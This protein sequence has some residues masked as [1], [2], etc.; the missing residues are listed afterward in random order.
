[1]PRV[2]ATLLLGLAPVVALGV[3]AWTHRW[4]ADDAFINLRVVD[5]LLHGFGPVFNHG[6]RVEAYTSPAWVAILAVADLVTPFR[7]EWLAVVLGGLLT[8]AGLAA[9]C[10][11]AVVLARAAG[12][13]GTALPAGA[14]VVVALAPFWDFATS[15]LETGLSF[16]WLGTVFWLLAELAARPDSRFARPRL[17][18]V[19]IG[20]GPLIR[21]DLAVFSAGFLGVLLVLHRLDGR[22]GRLRLLVWAAALPVAYQIFRMGY[23]AAVVPNTA[24]AKEAGEAYWARGWFYLRDFALTYALW[25]PALV[26]LGLVALELW[27][28][29]R[30]PPGRR[31][32]LVIAVPLACGFLHALYVVRVG[33]DFMHAR[34]LLPSTFALTLPVAMVVP[35]AWRSLRLVGVVALACWALVCGLTARPEDRGRPP[36]GDYLGTTDERVLYSAFAGHAHPVALGDFRSTSWVR[37]ATRMRTLAGRGRLLTA[38][39]QS[40]VPFQEPRWPPLLPRRSVPAPVVASFYSVGVAGYAA[41]RDV[42][43]VD[44]LGLGDPVASRIRFRNDVRFP[45]GTLR[46]PRFYPG[47]EKVLPAEWVIARFADP[48]S[49]RSLGPR[50]SDPELVAARAA[51]GCGSLKRIL[52]AVT[53]SMSP[54]RFFS[55]LGVAWKLRNFRLPADPQRAKNELCG[56]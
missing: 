54:R 47:H 10:R 30:T 50:A 40:Q 38:R 6:E 52:T 25:I 14:L 29:R 17:L 5:N 45:N 12:R 20:L 35:P 34:L 31:R 23:F 7:L 4:S 37:E 15:G 32:A 49:L 39:P 36:T 1:M 53:A 19:A 13:Q 46:P 51:L 27:G 8:L 2:S 42:H 21:P 44:R 18:A 11:G 56:R 41:G 9:G 28:S 16:A 33:G 55:N 24:I 48:A 22:L 26:V 43:V 3:F